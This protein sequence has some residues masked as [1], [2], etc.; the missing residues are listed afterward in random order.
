VYAIKY[1]FLGAIQGLTEFLPVSS[2]AHLVLF[3]EML[4]VKENQL[5]LD[6]ILHLGTLFAVVIFLFGDI[7]RLLKGRVLFYLIIATAL[8][9]AVVILG[10]D[11][12]PRLFLTPKTLALPLL[13]TG[14][15][16]LLT[17]KFSSGRRA[18]GQLNIGDAISLGIIQGFC[19]IPGISRSGLTISTLLFRDIDKETAFKFSFLASIPAVLGAVVFKL[20]DIT[21]IPTFE[22]KY[23]LIGFFISFLSGLLA[24]RVLLAVMRQ[25]RLHLFGY[26]CLAL[27]LIL[28]RQLR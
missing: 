17:K 21:Q 26:C 6:I 28:W 2:S 22:Y 1:A 10:D 27:A 25:A 18:S 7:K 14:V 15:V 11:F 8:T 19:V 3:Q 16:L 13:V 4:Q 23:M 5:V 12:F 20:N 24:L 9:A